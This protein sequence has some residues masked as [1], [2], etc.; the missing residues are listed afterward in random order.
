MLKVSVPNSLTPDSAWEK[1]KNFSN[2]LQKQY[3][4]K[5]KLISN[6]WNDKTKT[7]TVEGSVT[8]MFLPMTAKFTLAV[9]ED[10]IVIS[11]DSPAVSGGIFKPIVEAKIKQAL[12]ECL[13]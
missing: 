2:V 13:K 9:T 10:S 7:A 6:N 12:D 8:L 11:S 3:S 1:I 4:G 5:F